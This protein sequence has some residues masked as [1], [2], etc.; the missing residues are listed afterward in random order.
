MSASVGGVLPVHKGEVGLAVDVSMGERELEMVAAA[1]SDVVD[2]VVPDLLIEKIQETVLALKLLL[3]KVERQAVVEIRV[4]PES[5]LYEL[6]VERK[7]TKDLI[8]RL[9]LG[10]QTVLLLGLAFSFADQLAA[11]ENRLCVLPVAYGDDSKLSGECIDGLGAHAVETHGELEHVVVVLGP[12][13]NDADTLDHLAKR[14][15]TAEIPNPDLVSG[16]LDPYGRPEAHDELVNGIVY[17]LLEQY[18]DPVVQIAAVT[19]AANVHA[20]TKTDVFQ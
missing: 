11:L 13:V 16:Y 10:D 19:D 20:G 3:P 12:G 1:I 7:L 8:V 15:S 4:V 17:D 2:R 18:V 9:E 6:Q 5:L 14:N